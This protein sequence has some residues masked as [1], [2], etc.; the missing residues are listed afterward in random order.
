MYLG[1]EV[2][3][4]VNLGKQNL[5]AAVLE[6]ASIIQAFSKNEH[7]I[8]LKYLEIGNEPDL[9]MNNG[10]RARNYDVT[11]YINE[12]V[13]NSSSVSVFAADYRLF[14]PDGPN[15]PTLYLKP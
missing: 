11:D 10:L 7:G 15:S 9:Y 13:I 8:T 14:C 12:Y 4:G 1:T 3:W 2:I 5:T 6:A